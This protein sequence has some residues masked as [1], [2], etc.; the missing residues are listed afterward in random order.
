MTFTNWLREEYPAVRLF[1]DVD[2]EMTAEF[3]GEKAETCTP[4]TVR[5]L[6]ATL[7]KL[8]EGLYALNWIREDIVPTE[9]QVIGRN[10]PRGPYAA[11]EARAIQQWVEAR[12]SEYS[13]ALRFILSSGARI[14]ETLHLRS[15]KIFADKKCV[16]LVGKGGRVRRVQV[17]HAEVLNELDLSRRFVYLDDKKSLQ[18]KEGLE[19]VVRRGCNAL[20]IHRRGVHGFR[21]AAASEFINIKKALGGTEVEARH[22]LAMW[23]GHNPHRTEVTYAYV[24][25]ETSLRQVI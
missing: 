6:L 24:P 19:R 12:H 10:P 9:W 22:E 21:G 1:R 2:R 17:L 23:L 16:E 20:D 5:T 14:D 11:D 18:W 7:K 8:Q 3:L 25:R 15:D 13:Q 4:D